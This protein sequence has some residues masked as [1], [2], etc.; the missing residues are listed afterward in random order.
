ML[1]TTI[2]HLVPQPRQAAQPR[3]YV[4]R[5]RVPEPVEDTEPE[6]PTTVREPETNA[7]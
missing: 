2:R 7:A 5:H 1:F 3:A 6:A 4:G